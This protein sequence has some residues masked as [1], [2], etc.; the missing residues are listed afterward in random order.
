MKKIRLSW[1]FYSLC[2]LFLTTASFPARTE[3]MPEDDYEIVEPIP[4]SE[5][6][7]IIEKMQQ[8]PEQIDLKKSEFGI[9]FIP[10]FFLIG[11]IVIVVF[12]IVRSIIFEINVLKEHDQKAMQSVRKNK[13]QLT[14]RQKIFRC[15]LILDIIMLALAI[16][17]AFDRGFDA[18]YYVFL[19]FVTCV[20][21]AGFV[22]EKLSTWFKFILLL[23]VILYNPIVPVHLGDREIWVLINLI[24]MIL[25]CC[26]AVAVH[27][28]LKKQE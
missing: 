5:L 3:P 17:A 4:L 28:Q 8:E 21:L 25:L 1:I 7:G 10:V 18:W 26:G 27:R 6:A 24:T 12:S 19:R 15:F 2:L 9:N 13:I 20:T 23:L 16:I 22:L 14:E 11:F